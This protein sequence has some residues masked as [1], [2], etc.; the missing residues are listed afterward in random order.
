MKLR[1]GD[2]V[3]AYVGP[4]STLRETYLNGPHQTDGFSDNV[5]P[6]EMLRISRLLSRSG[7]SED[8]QVQGMAD[9]MVEY[10]RKCMFNKNRISPFESAYTQIISFDN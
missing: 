8:E 5:F 4:P 2:I 7:A 6:V 9:R 10:S 3:V 1:D